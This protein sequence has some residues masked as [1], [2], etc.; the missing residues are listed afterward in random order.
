MFNHETVLLNES[1]ELLNIKPNGIYVDATLG[2]AG[3]SSLIY[4]KINEEGK[5]ILFD[6]DIIAIENAKK[7]FFEKKNV[8][9]IKSNFANLKIELEKIGIKKIDGILFDLGVSSMQIDIDERGF[10]YMNNGP[11]DMRMDNNSKLTAYDVINEYSFHELKNIFKKYGEEEFAK[12]IARKIEN[13]REE[14]KIKTTKELT[15]IIFEAIPKKA[16]YGAKSHPA[17]RIF[18]AIRIEVNKELD[19]FE[20]AVQDAFE[21]LNEGGVISVITFHS[22]EDRICKYYFK[23]WSEESEGLKK[24]P[25]IPIELMH[26]GKLVKNKPILPSKEEC[27]NNSRSASAK[28]RGIR[29]VRV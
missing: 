18:Q 25:Q 23:L 29:R 13:K 20:K 7:I 6:Q 3:H 17:K 14:K 21:I 27:L 10:S 28:L 26:K 5:L 2:G 8:F 11:L 9:I 19:V 24:L 1:V 4:S 15:E 12:Q 22:L 16:F